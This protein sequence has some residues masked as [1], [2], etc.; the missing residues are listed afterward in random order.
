MT[1]YVLIAGAIIFLLFAAYDV[2]ALFHAKFSKK[3]LMNTLYIM[4]A[5]GI[6]LGGFLALRYPWTPFCGFLMLGAFVVYAL[7]SKYRETKKLKRLGGK[8]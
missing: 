2:W 8:I 3:T 6:T 1:L 7:I 5:F 4:F